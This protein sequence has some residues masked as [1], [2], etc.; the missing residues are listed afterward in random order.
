MN[1]IESQMMLIRQ[2]KA[3]IDKAEHDLAVAGTLPI[4]MTR[5]QLRTTQL[6]DAEAELER[7]EEE[8]Q[9]YAMSFGDAIRVEFTAYC[10][11][12]TAKE[13]SDGEAHLARIMWDNKVSDPRKSDRARVRIQLMI[14]SKAYEP[15]L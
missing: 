8:D 7:L 4:I 9:N 5:I 6:Y 3:E 12:K 13:L 10:N 14:N 2:I 15:N 1:A 11:T